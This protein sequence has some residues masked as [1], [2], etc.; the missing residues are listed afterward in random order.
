MVEDF[1]FDRDDAGGD[2]VEVLSDADGDIDDSAGLIGSAI[3]DADDFGAAI[4]QIGDADAGSEGEG[5]VGGG[6]GVVTE[7]LAARG[8]C[9]AIAAGA[10]IGGFAVR[11]FPG[12]KEMVLGKGGWDLVTI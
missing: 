7:W 4:F 11:D 1:H 5:F 3:C 12:G 2:H 8:L 6:A 10:V 9:S